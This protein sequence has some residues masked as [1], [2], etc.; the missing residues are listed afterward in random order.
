[1]SKVIKRIGSI[2]L[3][4]YQVAFH[5]TIKCPDDKIIKMNYD[6][7]YTHATMWKVG[8]TWYLRTVFKDLNAAKAELARLTEQSSSH[9][10]RIE[11]GTLIIVKISNRAAKKAS[12]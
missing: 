9:R 1:M 3:V 12:N 8:D 11:E 5:A 6:R 7:K 2:A 10:R 4:E